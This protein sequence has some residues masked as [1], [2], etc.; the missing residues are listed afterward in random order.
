MIFAGGK[1]QP[2][3]L[4]GESARYVNLILTAI[5]QTEVPVYIALNMRSDFIGDCAAFPGLTGVQ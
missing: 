4:A 3:E 2:M 5:H 1:V